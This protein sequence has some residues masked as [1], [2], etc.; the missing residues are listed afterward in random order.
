LLDGFSV[1]IGGCGDM[2]MTADLPRRLQRLVAHVCLSGRPGRPAVA[3]RLW[4]DVSEEHAHGS[5][6]SALWRLQK[7]APA[8]IE[9]NGDA[10]TVA[11]NVRLDVRE[12]RDWARRT[13]DFSSPVDE[14]VVP[15]PRLWGDLLPGWYDD[16]VLLERE[17]LTQLRVHSFEVL[18][19]RL[20]SSGRHCEAI[21]A[22]Y[23]AVQAE[24]L[25]ES[26]HRT[27]MRVHLAE[28]NPAEALR[29]FHLFRT[30]LRDELGIAP[31]ERMAELVRSV[32]HSRPPVR[33]RGWPPETGSTGR[34]P[35]TW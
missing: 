24:P 31:T 35:F 13:L 15:D 7:V 17:R 19:A 26:A 27:V 21:Q 11:D 18:A 3:G 23:A 8:L 2:E 6:R 9:A 29:V 20:A 33:G 5:L 22:A 32:S 25:R 4:P 10:L 28:G 12:L 34:V 16:W 14:L 30:L 1:L